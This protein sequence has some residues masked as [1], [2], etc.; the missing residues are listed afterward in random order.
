MAADTTD[1][2]VD[3]VDGD[4]LCW[5]DSEVKKIGSGTKKGM[6]RVAYVGYTTKPVWIQ[7]NTN[8]ICEHA[9]PRWTWTSL[10]AGSWSR[11]Q[12]GGGNKAF[13]SQKLLS[14]IK[15][16]TTSSSSNEGKGKSKSTSKGKS[17]QKSRA[18]RASTEFAAAAAIGSVAAAKAASKEY[19]AE[20]TAATREA[21]PPAVRDHRGPCGHCGELVFIDQKRQKSKKTSIYFHGAGAGC[22]A[23]EVNDLDQDDLDKTMMIAAEPSAKSKKAKRKSGGGQGGKSS[24]AKRAKAGSL[25]KKK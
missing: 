25:K 5:Y 15:K 2:A 8:F 19:A 3:D 16:S 20:E 21:S 9:D 10:G 13:K 24:S 6:A 4:D 17:S 12:N 18:A 14:L 23:N 22:R 1:V 7:F 11:S